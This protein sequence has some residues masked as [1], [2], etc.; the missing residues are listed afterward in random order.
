WGFWKPVIKA[1]KAE[2]PDF[3]ENRNFLRD[4]FNCIIGIIWQMT[5]VLAP[6]YLIIKE[7]YSMAFVVL[8]MI[9]TS[10]ILKKTWYNKLTSEK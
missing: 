4:T 3:M 9:I 7:Y 8:L 6:I 1:I 10:V 2:D 5:F